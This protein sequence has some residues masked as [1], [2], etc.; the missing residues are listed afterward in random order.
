M[1]HHLFLYT[2]SY[3]ACITS[4]AINMKWLTSLTILLS[5]NLVKNP[6]PEAPNFS[7]CSLNSIAN[8]D[9]LRVLLVKAYN[10][11]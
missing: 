7:T 6:G 3:I 11:V 4:N 1:Q 10:S 5:G 9:F 2:H 8:G